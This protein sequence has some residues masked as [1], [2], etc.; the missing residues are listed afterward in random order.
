MDCIEI[1]KEYDPITALL[2]KHN[3]MI[4]YVIKITILCFTEEY[5]PITALLQLDKYFWTL[6]HEC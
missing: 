4:L 6:L 5:N 3:P 2:K 1:P